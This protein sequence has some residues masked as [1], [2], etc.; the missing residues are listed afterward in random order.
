MVFRK[1]SVV[2]LLG[3]GM[4]YVLSGPIM[5]TQHTRSNYP[6]LH[7]TV[8]YLHANGSPPVDLETFLDRTTQAE[9][10]GL[11]FDGIDLALHDSYL[12]LSASDAQIKAFAKNLRERQ[13]TIGSIIAPSSQEPPGSER[14]LDGIRNS[15]RIGRRLRNL[16]RRHSEV[17]QIYY[18]IDPSAWEADPFGA[19]QSMILHL[20]SA[21]SIAE[22]FGERLALSRSLLDPPNQDWTSVRDLLRRV[23]RKSALG[24]HADL[25]HAIRQA[26]LQSDKAPKRPETEYED[27]D[28]SHSHSIEASIRAQADG[29]REWTSTL[30]VGQLEDSPAPHYLLPSDN[31]GMVRFTQHAG[32]WLHVEDGHLNRSLRWL[33]WDASPFP[34]AVLMKQATWDKAL[35]MM[36]SIRDAH[37]WKEATK[38]K[39]ARSPA[40]RK[41]VRRS[42]TTRGAASKKKAQTRRSTNK[43]IPG[44]RNSKLSTH[45]SRIASA[46]KKTAAKKVT[47]NAAKGRLSRSK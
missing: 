35:E 21:C 41:Q 44:A 19:Q 23:N 25:A 27:Y 2:L 39:P 17:I 45:H 4:A 36:V 22:E 47:K 40:K 11:R 34:A 1:T 42:T 29:L 38:G 13:L 24:F 16:A 8:G 31:A 33:T 26:H 32:P 9:V 15:C 30:L 3:L 43:R 18:S 5:K 10:G 14:W 46:A 20:C 37:G 28:L 7:T 12:P 6:K